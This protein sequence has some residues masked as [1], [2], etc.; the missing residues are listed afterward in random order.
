MFAVDWRQ[1][2]ATIREGPTASTNLM[3]RREGPAAIT[4]LMARSEI[5]HVNKVNPV[6][7]RTVA[8][9]SSIRYKGKRCLI[10]NK[11]FKDNSV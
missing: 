10:E 7:Y 8:L 6:P 3:A 5:P 1:C 4:H 2:R 9:N 11:T